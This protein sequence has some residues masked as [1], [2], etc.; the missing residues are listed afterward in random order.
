[1]LSVLG[2]LL[3]D[4]TMATRAQP[5]G[6]PEQGGSAEDGHDAFVRAKVRRGL[7]QSRDRSVMIPIEQAWRDLQR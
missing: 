3:Y 2:R 5:Q 6:E 4:R 1:M 7:E